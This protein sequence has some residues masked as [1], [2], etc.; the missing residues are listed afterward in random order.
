MDRNLATT[1]DDPQAQGST[2]SQV[3]SQSQPPS[4]LPSRRATPTPILITSIESK[5]T[6]TP[7]PIL[8]Q[9]GAP[10]HEKENDQLYETPEE[11]PVG[12]GPTPPPKTINV[13][14][15][16]P[17]LLEPMVS[18]R[19]QTMSSQHAEETAPLRVLDRT[20]TRS[21]DASMALRPGVDWIVPIGDAVRNLLLIFLSDIELTLCTP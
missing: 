1:K 17:S 4:L 21:K 19:R 13:G 10:L 16:A 14:S 18:T 12:V 9:Q 5:R 3:P 15:I 7:Q 2:S 20:R 8:V 6:S 11:S